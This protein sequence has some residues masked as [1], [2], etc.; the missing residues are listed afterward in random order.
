MNCDGIQ[1]QEQLT[2]SS[3]DGCELGLPQQMMSA[4][5]KGISRNWIGGKAKRRVLHGVSSEDR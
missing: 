3:G 1:K 5:T 4:G 2:C